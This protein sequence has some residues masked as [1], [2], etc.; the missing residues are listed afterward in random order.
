MLRRTKECAEAGRIL[1]S[2]WLCHAHIEP[3]FNIEPYAMSLQLVLSL[4]MCI[5]LYAG[6]RTLLFRPHGK[7][8]GQNMLLWLFL[9]LGVC[10]TGNGEIYI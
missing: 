9:S 7:W 10:K 8:L 1:Y 4:L 5:Y 6:R 3:D 2:S